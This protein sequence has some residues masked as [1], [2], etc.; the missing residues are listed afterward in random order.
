MV[1]NIVSVVFAI[2][3]QIY[4]PAGWDTVKIASIILRN[5][6][7]GVP[8]EYGAAAEIMQIRSDNFPG[9]NQSE[10]NKGL[11]IFIH[12]IPPLFWTFHCMWSSPRL[13]FD[14]RCQTK[15]ALN[16]SRPTSLHWS[17][18]YRYLIR[19]THLYRRTKLQGNSLWT[20]NKQCTCSYWK[21]AQDPKV[22][23]QDVPE[24]N[25]TLALMPGSYHVQSIPSGR[26]LLGTQISQCWWWADI[27]AEFWE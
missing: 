9:N 3:S 21:P 11:E 7:R 10:F 14:G 18:F 26:E 15:S 23:V 16:K 25:A 4:R 13:W 6:K 12:P 24:V 17:K 5:L 8:Q 19:P 22:K 20:Q 1:P 27:W 2:I